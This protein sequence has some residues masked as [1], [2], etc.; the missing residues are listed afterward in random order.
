MLQ[1]LLQETRS[2]FST[3]TSETLTHNASTHT[4]LHNASTQLHA[5]R[6][7]LTVSDEKHAET[8]KAWSAATLSRVAQAQR[9]V[10]AEATTEKNTITTLSRACAVRDEECERERAQSVETLTHAL[11][12][13]THALAQIKTHRER[14]NEQI[15]ALN[16]LTQ[17]ELDRDLNAFVAAR[18]QANAKMTANSTSHM[19]EEAQVTQ[20]SRETLNTVGQERSDLLTTVEDTQIRERGDTPVEPPHTVEK[21]WA[22]TREASLIRAETVQRYTVQETDWKQRIFELTERVIV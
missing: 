1:A 4:L 13:H 15:L 19:Q 3:V 10:S 16:K 14:E 8:E 11:T 22:R 2:V 6:Q 21:E 9:D 18:E 5:L 7:S 20:Q 12:Q 17:D